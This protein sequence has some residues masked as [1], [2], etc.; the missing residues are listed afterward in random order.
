MAL[1]SQSA[2]HHW[3]HTLSDVAVHDDVVLLDDCDPADLIVIAVFLVLHL[4]RAA[5]VLLSLNDVPTEHLG[6]LYF[7]LR[8][9]EDIIVVVYVFYYLDWLLLILFLR[10]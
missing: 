9:V 7:D 1:I 8:V 2:P 10:F 5:V 3:L 4:L 6:I